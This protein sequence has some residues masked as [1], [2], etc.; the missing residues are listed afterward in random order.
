MNMHE[1][2]NKWSVAK[3][4]FGCVSMLIECAVSSIATF[5]PHRTLQQ[6]QDLNLA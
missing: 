5:F 3:L 4:I 6:N 2:R 1:D